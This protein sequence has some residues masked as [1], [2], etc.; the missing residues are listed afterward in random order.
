MTVFDFVDML[1]L[2]KVNRIKTTERSLLYVIF[3]LVQV[4]AYVFQIFYNKHA[5]FLFLK[6]CEILHL[7]PVPSLFCF[8]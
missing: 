8:A 4:L 6:I 1:S 2:V 3:I 5:L 7:R